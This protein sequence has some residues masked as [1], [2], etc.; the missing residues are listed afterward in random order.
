MPGTT[1]W[2]NEFYRTDFQAELG[3]GFAPI[4]SRDET[5]RAFPNSC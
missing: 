3:L 1:E 4:K 2:E 5:V